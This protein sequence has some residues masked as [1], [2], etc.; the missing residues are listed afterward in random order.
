MLN[1]RGLQ[2]IDSPKG[3][4]QIKATTDFSFILYSA[5]LTVP[6]ELLYN[7]YFILFRIVSYVAQIAYVSRRSDKMETDKVRFEN[8]ARTHFRSR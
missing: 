3:H 8:L 1:K 4:Y 6:V 5:E 7:G 2:W